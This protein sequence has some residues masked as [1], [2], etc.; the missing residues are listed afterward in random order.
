VAE[1]KIPSNDGKPVEPRDVAVDSHGNIFVA[2]NSDGTVRKF[3]SQGNPAGSWGGTAKNGEPMFKELFGIVIDPSNDSVYVLD[4]GAGAVLHF[5]AQGNL[6]GDMLKSHLYYPRGLALG[7][8]GEILVA[9]TGGQ[10]IVR[11]SAAQGNIVGE[12]GHPPESSGDVCEPVDV[13]ASS[14][15]ETFLF[16]ARN[17][18]IQHFTADG[19]LDKQWAVTGKIAARD[20]GHLALDQHDRLYFA[21]PSKKEINVFNKAGEILAT[22]PQ[23]SGESPVG[24]FVDKEN[25]YVTY[26]ESGVVRKFKLPPTQQ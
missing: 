24:L 1:I 23:E 7:Q 20:S 9:D 3:D 18:R 25:M 16:D 14:N 12:F 8:N 6:K 4:S 10:K 17:D 5:D 21:V 22:W 13:V 19:T 11:A 26:P 15:G 2:C